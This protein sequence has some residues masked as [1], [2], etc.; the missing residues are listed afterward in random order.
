MSISRSWFSKIPPA[1]LILSLFGLYLHTL[2]PGLTWANGGADGGDLIAAAAT[3]GIPHPTGYPT[4]LLLAQ[5]FQA[6]PLG[7]LAFRTNLMSAVATSLAAGLVYTLVMR[8]L[9][10]A[11]P[12][13][14]WPAGLLAGYAFGLAPLVWSQAVITEVYALHV[15]FIVLIIYLATFPVSSSESRPKRL[16]GLLGLVCGLALGNHVTSGLLVPAA[17]LTGSISRQ[18]AIEG[19]PQA[20]WGKLRS[21]RLDWKVLLRQSVWLVAG[22]SIYLLLPV[23]ALSGSAINWGGPLTPGRF[24]WLVSGQLYRDYYLNMS[25]GEVLIRLQ[26]AATL[27]LEQFGYVGMILGIFGLVFSFTPSRLYV[28]T[29]WTAA[30]ST[31]FAL[32]YGAGDSYVYLIPA[33][34]SFAIWI[35]LGLTGLIKS[36]SHIRPRFAWILYPLFLVYLFV[37]AIHTFPVVDASHDLRA[38][39]FG[40]RVLETAPESAVLFVDGDRAVFALWYFHFALHERPDLAVLATDLLHFDWYQESLRKAY[41][42]LVLPGPFPFASTVIAANPERAYCYVTYDLQADIAC[43]DASGY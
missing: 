15:F 18:P 3:G 1:F 34:A 42:A 40:N 7:S 16:D 38:E 27:L 21:W 13:N 9:S 28:L 20:I 4:Y 17:L 12:K 6:I 8:F 36:L 32:L 14:Y 19:T 29:V 31:I 2:A 23:R 39:E 30:V 24:W 10:P 11:N 5:I 26:A 37:M 25:I 41:P 35:S 33:C 43:K 22:L